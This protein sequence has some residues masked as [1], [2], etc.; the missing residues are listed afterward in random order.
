MRVLDKR[1]L[2]PLVATILLILL[3]IAAMVI[4]SSA[5]IPFVKEKMNEA[6]ECSEIIKTADALT[7]DAEDGYACYDDA[8]NVNI[9]IHR[10]NLEIKG[11]KVSIRGGGDSKIV[12]I[13]NNTDGTGIGVSML[14][15]SATLVLPG[16]GGEKTYLISTALSLIESAVIAPIMPSG[17]L[18]KETDEVELEAC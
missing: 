2:S 3:S 8:G 13:E 9:T 16:K 18:C 15:G 14:D 12:D 6:Q 11:I 1:G 7:I 17:Q 5:I 4:L 10:G